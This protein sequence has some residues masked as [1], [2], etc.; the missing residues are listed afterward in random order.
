M[1]L[2]FGARFSEANIK[3]KCFCTTHIFTANPQTNRIEAPDEPGPDSRTTK[4]NQPDLNQ[5]FL[6]KVISE[7]HPNSN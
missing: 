1:S 5:I 6:A 7:S 2:E 4:L 3:N